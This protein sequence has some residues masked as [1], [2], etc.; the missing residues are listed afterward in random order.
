[1]ARPRKDREPPLFIQRADLLS[2]EEILRTS[3]PLSPLRGVY[4]LLDRGKVV[5]IGRSVNCYVRI[6]THFD[7]CTKVFDS[8][9]VIE[10]KEKELDDL[11]MQYIG[12]FMPKYNVVVPQDGSNRLRRVL[13][14]A[15]F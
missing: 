12:K 1:M 6:G 9:Y 8:Y 3:I 2:E 10:C 5:Y 7:E 13:S 15:A 4:F 14:N 11:E